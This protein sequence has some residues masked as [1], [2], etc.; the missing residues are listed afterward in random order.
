MITN[1][2]KR[3]YREI[4]NAEELENQRK[5]LEEKS[6]K[7]NREVKASVWLVESKARSNKE[8]TKIYIDKKH[9]KI[10]ALAGTSTTIGVIC[11]ILLKFY[12][13]QARSF[14]LRLAL[15]EGKVL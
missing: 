6:E 3:I 12:I 13:H 14:S 8:W 11:L 5:E 7:R 4:K 2:V 10:A 15:L 1:I 9:K